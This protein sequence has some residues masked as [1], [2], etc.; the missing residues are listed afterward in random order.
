MNRNLIVAVMLCFGSSALAQTNPA[1]ALPGKLSPSDWIKLGKNFGNRGE[2]QFG[3]DKSPTAGAC[4]AYAVRAR[5]LM[6]GPCRDVF[7]L[8]RDGTPV[9]HLGAAI[10]YSGQTPN[11][12]GRAGFN[13]GPAGAAA[14]NEV[15]TRIPYLEAV[16]SMHV[17]S[18]ASYLGKITTVDYMV[19]R[20]NGRL[21]HGPEVKLDVP[22]ADLRGLLP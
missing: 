12:T 17:P 9:F 16:A 22:L 15:S 5:V 10:L 21:D 2:W 18:W 13:V 4:A 14:L 20:I 7:L 3:F 1:A 8:A 19:G 11:Y 6:A